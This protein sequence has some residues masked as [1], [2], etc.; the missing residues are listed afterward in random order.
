M[1]SVFKAV[2]E[3]GVRDERSTVGVEKAV[4]ESGRL[5]TR[6]RLIPRHPQRNGRSSRSDETVIHAQVVN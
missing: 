5:W 2:D 1:D 3:D 6:A 4:G